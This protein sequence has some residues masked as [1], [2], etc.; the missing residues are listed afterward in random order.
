[1]TLLDIDTRPASAT[2]GKFV[3]RQG[4]ERPSTMANF[5][6]EGFTMATESTCQNGFKSVFYA[7]DSSDAGHAIRR[8]SIPCGAFL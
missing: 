4:F 3:V 8:D 1:M 6:N 7:D 2:R 5:N